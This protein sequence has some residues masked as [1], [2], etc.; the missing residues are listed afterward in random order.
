[1]THELGEPVWLAVWGSPTSETG[2]LSAK[3]VIMDAVSIDVSN[4]VEMGQEPANENRWFA[5]FFFRSLLTEG[6]FTDGE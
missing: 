5:L 3:S 2:D 1:M 4:R 6:V